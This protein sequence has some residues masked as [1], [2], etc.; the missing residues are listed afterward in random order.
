[1][2]LATVIWGVGKTLLVVAGLLGIVAGL[3]LMA[4]RVG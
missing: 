2:I 4:S 1:M 3:F